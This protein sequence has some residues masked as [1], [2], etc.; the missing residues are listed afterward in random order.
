V[1]VVGDSDVD[2]GFFGDW[3]K[4]AGVAVGHVKTDR[5]IEWNSGECE[6]LD[7]AGVNKCFLCSRVDES[8]CSDGGSVG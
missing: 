2:G 6:F 5:A 1:V 7:K 3:A 8:V 4:G